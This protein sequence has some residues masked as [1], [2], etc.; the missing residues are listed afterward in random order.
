MTLLSFDRIEDAPAWWPRDLTP[1]R[2][3]T[4]RDMTRAT[5]GGHAAAAAAL[6]GRVL[7]PWQRYGLDV[8]LE[9]DDRGIF[10]YSHVICTVQ[11]Q[12][13]KTDL[14]QTGGLQ[15]ALMGPARQVWHTAQSGQ[16]ASAKWRELAESFE[17]A[18]QLRQLAQPGAKGLRY[19]N[20]SEGITLVNGS[21]IR[22]HPPTEKALHGKQS[23]RNSIDE[24]WAHSLA[25]GNALRQAIGP[26]TTTRR[27]ATGQRPQLW[28]LST[29]GTVES[30]FLNPLLDEAR[31]GGDSAVCLLDW[32]LRDDDDGTDLDVVA[33]R[34]PGYGYL[35]DEVTLQ[36][37][38]RLF[39]DAPGEFA[40]AFGNRRTGSTE[41]LLPEGPWNDA[42][43]REAYPAGRPCIGA[44]VGLDGVDAAIVVGVRV[45]GRTR[46]VKVIKGGYG[47]GSSWA[48]RR[49]LE[50]ATKH[51]V[52][53]VIDR[54]GPS[55]GLH[56]A[57]V[58]AGI[59]V[60]PFDSQAAA[61]AAS[62]ILE[63][64]TD[65]EGPSWRYVPHH[66][67]DA[68]AELATRRYYAD[69]AWVIGRRASV[70]STAALEAAGLA[71]W[72]VDHLPDEVG[73][74]LF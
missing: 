67:L 8:A 45:D 15:N 14:D 64:I 37:Q 48:I 46:V 2:H 42:A 13:G 4:A 22:P 74:Q 63:G 16:D 3:A 25:A 9:V 6:R 68:A 7:L 33:S 43:W 70:G 59:E 18:P 73:P 53:V 30:G 52:P 55:A 49:L 31:E 54:R 56:D 41:R 38:A 11:R 66:A 44:A 51:G 35:L 17:A 62:A 72:G 65:E 28:T 36:D 26:T 58:R 23:D 1:P 32:G 10:V 60:L 27:T 19:S 20:G 29:E 12:A 50:V 69:G 5:Y 21:K 24:A 40:R 47:P 61:A 39:A 71:A 34:H 57:A